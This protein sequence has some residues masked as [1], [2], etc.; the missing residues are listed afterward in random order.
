MDNEVWDEC[1]VMN[2]SNVEDLFLFYNSLVNLS[3]INNYVIY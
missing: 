1:V 2:G 3:I